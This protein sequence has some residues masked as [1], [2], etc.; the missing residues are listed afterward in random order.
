MSLEKEKQSSGEIVDTQ[1]LKQLYSHVKPYRAQF[2]FLV[3][4][5]IAMAALA[6]T[7]PYFIQ[8]AID[9]YVAKGDAP[10]L[11]NIIYV[12]VGLMILQAVVQWAH[13]FYSGW[14]GQVIIKDIRVNLYKHL[15]KLRL[16]FF[17]NTP[18]GRLVTR[19]VS[20]IETLA[21]VFSEGLAAIIGDLLQLVTILGVMFYIDWKLTLVSL[22]TLPLMII[23]TYIFKEKIK[24]TF[25]DVRNAV[26]N[27]NSFLQEHITGMNIVQIFNREDREFEKFKSIN[28]EH[29]TAHIKSVLYYSIYF[30]VAEIIQ[31]IGIGLVVWYGAVGVLGMDLQVGILISFIMYLQLFFRPIRMIADRFNTLQM[32]VVSSSR[33]FKLLESDEHIANEGELKPE[34]VKGNISL[35]HVWFA[36]NNDEYVLK[37][38]NFEVKSGQTVA[39]VGATGAGKSSIINLISRFYEINEGVISIDG[40]DIRDFDLGILRKHIGVVLQDVFLFSDTIYYNITLGNPSISREQVMD[41]AEQVGARKFIERLPGG[42]DYNVME[43]GA[44]LSVGQRQ[45][46][47]FVRAMVYNPEII[48]LD[49]ATSSVDT[50]TE[51]LIQESIDKMMKGRTSIVI[52]HRLS[53]IQK[54]DKI[55]VLNKG[56]I[57]ETGTHTELLELGGHYTQLH[58]MQLKTMAI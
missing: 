34:S 26:S 25:N 4:L 53:T 55:I 2:Y 41:A 32:G 5:T 57:V 18:I 43:R 9:D 27:L 11:L 24:V 30:P 23:S 58:Q 39:L 7:R 50:E 13:T 1:V 3:F 31:A 37:D 44:T 29:R 22:C 17:D 47:S 12:L 56:E 49:E 14:I 52:A 54:A 15:L 19:N 48:I 36:Y 51:E 6:P 28:K 38:I 16:K 46:I 45:L 10:G 20:D 21:D 8:V 42:L 35:E 33:I 40:K